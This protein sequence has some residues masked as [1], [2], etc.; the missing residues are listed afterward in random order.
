MTYFW[1]DATLLDI[2]LLLLAG[3]DIKLA[4]KQILANFQ[5]RTINILI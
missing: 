3:M 4:H 2:K 5:N 1:F